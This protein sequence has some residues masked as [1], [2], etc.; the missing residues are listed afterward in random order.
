MIAS[1][2]ASSSLYAYT[3]ISATSTRNLSCTDLT[4]RENRRG[5]P[6]DQSLDCGQPGVGTFF[7]E[8]RVEGDGE[9]GFSEV[10]EVVI[11][12]EEETVSRCA[13]HRSQI[14]VPSVYFD[15][16]LPVPFCTSA[17]KCSRLRDLIE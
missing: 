10:K 15:R 16:E 13:E 1:P 14:H 12:S 9:V 4:Y 17:A 8:T 7:G 11:E 5:L 6:V 2:S 3:R